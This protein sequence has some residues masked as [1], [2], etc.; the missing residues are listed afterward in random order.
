MQQ[1]NI[2][3][4]CMI[5]SLMFRYLKCE[6]LVFDSVSF[7]KHKNILRDNFR[8]FF[9]SE[10]IS[11][12]SLNH[13]TPTGLS[14]ELNFM[15]CHR[16]RKENHRHAFLEDLL[17]IRFRNM[18]LGQKY[19]DAKPFW[20][21]CLIFI[22]DQHTVLETDSRGNKEAK[23]NFVER[24]LFSFSNICSPYVLPLNDS[25]YAPQSAFS[26]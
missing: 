7:G 14:S 19:R 13:T 5:N 21:V 20:V 24:F 3:L 4:F 26:H 9:I 16:Y 1:P 17:G 11:L 15:R 8:F 10:Q 22:Y 12:G 18:S 2:W 25:E 23:W 6:K